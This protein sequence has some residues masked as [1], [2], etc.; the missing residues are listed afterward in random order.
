MLLV[1]FGWQRHALLGCEPLQL[2]VGLG[3]IVNHS[4]AERVDGSIRGIR[5]RLFAMR[6][7]GH[8]AHGGA[9]HERGVGAGRMP[10]RRISFLLPGC[11]GCVGSE[12]AAGEREC[13]HERGR[14]Q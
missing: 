4:P 3:V 10:F 6:N 13:A 1:Q 2:F 9:L 11:G 7:F 5:R 8:A 14:S 12:C